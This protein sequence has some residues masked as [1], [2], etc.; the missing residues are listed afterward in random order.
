MGDSGSRVCV[1]LGEKL[2]R[3]GFGEQHPFGNDRMYAFQEEFRK[4]GL[5]GRARV[6]SPVSGSRAHLALFHDS[7]YLDFLETRSHEGGGFLDG[8]DTPI[9]RGVWEASLTVAG[10]VC[11]AADRLLAGECRYAL[12]PIAGLHHAR[13]DGAAGFCAINDCGI[14]IE[15]LKRQGVGRIAYVDIDAHHGDGVYYAF[16]SDPSVII[17]DFHEDGRYLYPGTG[18]VTETGKGSAAGTKLNVPL[19]PEADDALF[20]KLWPRAEAFLQRYQPDFFILQAGADSVAG[21]PITHLELSART[22]A[23]VAR[24]LAGMDGRPLLVLGGGGYNRSN[25]AQAWS[26]VVEALLD[27]ARS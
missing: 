24:A 22:H 19:P 6:L 11:D 1:Y 3:Y 26:G 9:F 8:G 23:R 15:Y 25:L 13:R 14:V 21:D 17:V 10:S 12:V 4:R 20:S 16:E 18:A 27:T 2:A 5:D 7:S